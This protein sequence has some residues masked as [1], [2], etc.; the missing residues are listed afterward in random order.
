MSHIKTCLIVA[1]GKGTRLKGFGDLKPLV[2]L[3]GKPLIEHA[4]LAAASSGVDRFVVV[5]GYKSALLNNFLES[6]R[7]KYQ[8]S[9]TIAHNPHYEKAN[10]V[11]VLAAEQYLDKPFLLAMCDHVVEPSLYKALQNADI[12]SASIGLGVDY[13]LD[14]P[15]VDLSDVTRVALDGHYITDIGK[16]IPSYDAFDAGVFRASPAL[17]G[18]IRDSVNETGDCSISGGM[19]IFART[20]RAIAIDIGNT[21]WIDVDS[22]DMHNR[23]HAWLHPEM[24]AETGAEKGQKIVAVGHRGTATFAPENTIVA[25][26]AAF[27]LGAR[28]IEFDI[29]C[30]RD[31]QFVL[32]HDATVNRTTD[33]RGRVED[34]TLEQIQMLDAGMRKGSAFTGEG[35]PTLREALR[36]VKG[37]FCV[38]LDFKSGPRHSAE[39][40]AEVLEEEGFLSNQLVTVFA[41]RR[42]F[43]KL[44]SLC[45]QYGLRP[46]YIS[47]RKTR[48]L[49]NAYPLEVMGLR[50]FS[51]AQHAARTIRASNLHLFCNVMGRADNERGYSNAVKAGAR[52][53]QTD[54]L[55]KLVPFLEQHNLLETRV[56]GRDFQPVERLRGTVME[57]FVPGMQFST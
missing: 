43:K 9:I 18:A 57:N 46:H 14:N 31:G 11:S 25:H 33:G 36:N 35:V 15:D 26:E 34:L 52:F 19:R 23:A 20:R 48:L 47:A 45:P 55:D 37:R 21:R 38:D 29:R 2:N 50:R 1:A 5:T 16:S 8:W 41:R 44:K 13:R 27:A 40:L 22:P 24:S 7:A 12:D 39:I 51:F 32:M 54:H 42:H 49:A 4:M 56:L 17:F 3:C 6:L 10:G 30:T 53:I 28:A